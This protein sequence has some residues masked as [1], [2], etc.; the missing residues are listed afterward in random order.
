MA[1]PEWKSRCTFFFVSHYH[2]MAPWEVK[3]SFIDTDRKAIRG[4]F[5]EVL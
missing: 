2:S 3:T 5:M 1:D 4:Q